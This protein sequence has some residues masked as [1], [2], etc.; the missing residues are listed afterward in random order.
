MAPPKC[1]D[2][3]IKE[4]KDVMLCIYQE[5]RANA[6]HHESQISAVSNIILLSTMGLVGFMANDYHLDRK[7]LPLLFGL[8]IT[9][10]YGPFFISYHFKRIRRS[11]KRAEEY[12]KALD[13]LLFKG[14]DFSQT[15]KDIHHPDDFEPDKLRGLTLVAAALR[16]LWPLTI[17]LIGIIITAYVSSK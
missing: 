10:I 6:R 9:G 8:I 3:L 12:Y 15:F 7:D 11:K 17:S 5:N 14:V 13:E 1:L 2:N 4:Q 16:I